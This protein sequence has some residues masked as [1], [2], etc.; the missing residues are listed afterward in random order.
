MERITGR[1]ISHRVE[2]IPNGLIPIDEFLGEKPSEGD[3]VRGYLGRQGVHW[4]NSQCS[5]DF[6]RKLA[7]QK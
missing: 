4:R 1:I 5:K 3:A 6:I 2:D 7:E